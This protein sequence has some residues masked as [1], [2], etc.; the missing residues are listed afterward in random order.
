MWTLIIVV[1][2]ILTLY[3]GYRW[4]RYLKAS[5][6]VDKMIDETPQAVWDKMNWNVY[7]WFVDNFYSGNAHVRCALLSSEKIYKVF[8]DNYGTKYDDRNIKQFMDEV[9]KQEKVLE[10]IK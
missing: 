4:W 7:V 5:K 9:I 1:L 2:S 8:T 10:G 3:R 6:M